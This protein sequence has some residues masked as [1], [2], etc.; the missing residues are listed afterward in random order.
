M[1]TRTMPLA[2]MTGVMGLVFTTAAFAQN[3]NA[4]RVAGQ[5]TKIDGKTLTIATTGAQPAETA[6]TCNDQTKFVRDGE[7]AAATF[8]DLQVGQPVRAY[9]TSSG[10]IALAVMIATPS[11]VP[12]PSA[13]VTRVAGQLTKIDGKALTIATGEND[14]EA[15]VVTCTDKTSFRREGDRSGT[16]AKFEDLQVG[17]A[18]RVYCTAD[19]TALGV[20]IASAPATKPKE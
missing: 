4:V 13:A 14:S 20:I 19:K 9:Y 5:L 7:K 18:V 8:A 10:K 1:S 6:I 16:Q 12:P 3:T 2:L 15:T 11:S 17:Q